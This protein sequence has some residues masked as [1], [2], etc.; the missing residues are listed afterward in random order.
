MWTEI[1]DIIGPMLTS[2]MASGQ[3]TWSEDLLLP[4]N[5]HGYWEE[6]YW[7]YSYSPLH[8]DEGTVRGV[9]TA[10]TETTERVVGERR[11]A[12]LQDL[13]T[14]A[15]SARSAAG[16]LVAQALGRAAKDIPFAAVYLRTPGTDELALTAS[17]PPETSPA[18]FTPG[19]DHTQAVEVL[20]S[21][22]PVTLTISAPGWPRCPR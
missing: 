14:L 7:T 4:M 18:P 13:G 1:W 22:Q 3:A 9:F 21:G 15:G 20:R 12:V 5:R 17:S 6:T 11:L 2:V 16:R 10:V 19:R 8:D